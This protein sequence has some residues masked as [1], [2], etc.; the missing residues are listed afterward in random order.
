M[1]AFLE[2]L[3]PSI[4]SVLQD[5]YSMN[6]EE[7]SRDELAKRLGIKRNTLDQRIRRAIKALRV[8]KK[9]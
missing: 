3:P 1:R 4:Q 5:V 7:F 6:E 8:R 2:H 9:T